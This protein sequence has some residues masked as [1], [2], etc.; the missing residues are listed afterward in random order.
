MSVLEVLHQI[1]IDTFLSNEYIIL[2]GVN[3]ETTQTNLVKCK[4]V[5]IFR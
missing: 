1:N 3:I 2:Y 5:Q 4:Q